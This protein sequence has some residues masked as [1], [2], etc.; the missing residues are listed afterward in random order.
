MKSIMK[1]FFALLISCSVAAGM[2]VMPSYAEDAEF[3]AVC[4]VEN[5]IYSISGRGNG[6][7]INVIINPAEEDINAFTAEILSQSNHIAFSVENGSDGFQKRFTL[8]QDF[9]DGEYKSVVW[10]GAEEHILYFMSG[11]EDYKNELLSKKIKDGF[12]EET[13]VRYGEQ[14]GIDVNSYKA[15]KES[16]KSAIED[17]LGKTEITD[18]TA[19]YNASVQKALFARLENTQE[20]YDILVLLNTDFEYYNKLDDST[21]QSVLLKL[22]KNLP[23]TPEQLKALAEQYSKESYQNINK[24]PSGG[25]T[26]G[27]SGSSSGGSRGPSAGSSV[28]T[29]NG[30][31]AGEKPTAEPSQESLSDISGHWAKDVVEELVKKGIV[32][33][34]SDGRFYPDNNITRAEFSKMLAESIG[35]KQGQGQQQFSDVDTSSWYCGYVT[36]LCEMGII[37]GFGDG[38]F[39]PDDNITRQDIAVMVYRVLEQRG[40]EPEKEK[41]F[42]DKSQISEY[43]LNAVS[44][45]GGAGIISGFDDGS[46][47][48]V[49]LSTRAEAAAIVLRTYNNIE[50]IGIL[51]T[52]ENTEDKA[53]REEKTEA[54]TLLVKNEM[55]KKEARTAEADQLIPKLLNRPMRGVTRAGFISDVSDLI[56]PVSVIATEQ[57]FTDLPVSREETSSI[58]VMAD[59][60]FIASEGE[61]YP[62]DIINVSDAIKIMVCA[63]GYKDFA[64]AAG[65]WPTGY[66]QAAEKAELWYNVSRTT[67]GKL[68]EETAKLMLLNMLQSRAVTIGRASGDKIEYVTDDKTLLEKVFGI[69][70]STGIVEETTL[71]SLKRIGIS[72]GKNIIVGDKKYFADNEN[73]DYLSYLG[74]HVNVYHTEENEVFMLAKTE[75]NKTAAF[76]VDGAWLEN[77]LTIK[78]EDESGKTTIKCKLDDDYYFLYND[79]LSSGVPE[80]ILAAAGDGTVEILDNN[81]D[82]KYD[83][84]SIKNPE[85]VVVDS[86]SRTNRLIY[87]KNSS[88]NLIDLYDDDIMLHIE[89]RNGNQIRFIDVSGGEIYELYTTEDKKLVNLKLMSKVL[90]GAVSVKSK[91]KLTINGTE[92]KTTE[93]FNQYYDNILTL[94]NKYLF[95]LSSAGK[96]IAFDGSASN[97]KL[98]YVSGAGWEDGKADESMFIRLFTQDNKFETYTA[99][100]KLTIDGKSADIKRLYEKLLTNGMLNDQLIRYRVDEEGKIKAVD[101]AEVNTS[102]MIGEKKADENSLTEYKFSQ[103]SFY[104]KDTVDLMYPSFNVSGSIVFV[105]P[106]DIQDKDAYKVTS[107]SFFT[108]GQS[109]SN[110]RVYNLSEIG[111]AEAVVARSD[112]P[113]P[114]LSKYTNSFVIEKVQEAVNETEDETMMRVYGWEN[115]KYRSYFIDND[116]SIYK[117][118]GEKLGFGDVIRFYSDGDVIKLIICDFD[119]NESVFARNSSTDAADMNGGNKDVMYQFGEAYMLGSDYIYIGGG[120]DGRDMSVSQLRNFAVDTANIAVINMSEQT[121]K[122]GKLSDIRTYKNYGTGD[123]VLIRQT[124]LF[125][126]AIYVYVQ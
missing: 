35:V 62:D 10:D 111:V 15:L 53:D 97:M 89:G 65:G 115:Q 76:P 75:K 57:Y 32:S 41:E 105:I 7:R 43:A 16:V 122:T 60:G 3:A 37:S 100:K 19:Q 61:F 101:F 48:P 78:Y 108:D 120:D 88:E 102:D 58:Q 117:A 8:P 85:Y 95:N 50:N 51:Q 124:N 12:L 69:Y 22:L 80:Q 47:R 90:A 81:N 9:S 66:M 44:R 26:G 31:T 28:I 18:F 119:A 74:Y 82:G 77:N 38:L 103:S 93:Y 42:S 99:G 34:S 39:R 73:E 92:Y 17:E 68:D 25:L 71:N 23:G 84:M 116:V 110:L 109:Y 30:Q 104:Y 45:L 123:I 2:Y 121:V 20:M 29:T 96:I 91:D 63:L 112:T 40:I 55:T 79:A 64:E 49:D 59:K 98:G 52:R 33:G 24:N 11:S 6:D 46:F 94:G 113:I 83:I 86:I 72:K 114:Q 106:N 13:V 5:G 87:D 36:A 1:R 118:S 126:K 54:N 107:S 14:Y 4:A 67:D 70:V 27:S 125:T 56:N 21:R